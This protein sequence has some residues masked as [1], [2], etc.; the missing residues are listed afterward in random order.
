M[1]LARRGLTLK[2][3][4]INQATEF[5]EA[6]HQPSLFVENDTSR[7]RQQVPSGSHSSAV[8]ENE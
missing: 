1:E 2:A 4:F 7:Q 6:S 8:E 3:W 5:L